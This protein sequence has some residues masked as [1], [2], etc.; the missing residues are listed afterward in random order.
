M[1]GR[2]VA[3]DPRDVAAHARD[4]ADARRRE[5]A[6]VLCGGGPGAYDIVRALGL[7]GIGSAVCSSEPGDVAFRSRYARQMLLLPE[8]GEA[9]FPRICDRLSAFSSARPDRP[10]LFHVGDSE[11]MFLSRFRNVLEASYRFLLPPPGVLEALM[12][13]VRFLDLA[14]K[15][16]LPVPA[17]QAF[18]EAAEV[19]AATIAMPCI[20]KPAYN[21]DWFWE[22]EALRTQFGDYK[23]ALRRFESRGALLEFCAALP[24][25]PAGF[26]V[27]SYVDGGDERIVSFH[28]YFDE[29]S[30]CLGSFLTREI[31]TNPPHSGDLA[32]CETIHDEDLA[33]LSVACL[34]RLGFRGIVKVDYK[35]DERARAYKMLEIEPHYQSWHLLGAY[36]GVNLP[37]IAYGH[38]RDARADRAGA[39]RES[40]RLLYF[41]QDFKAYWCG[42]RKTGEW[43][44]RRYLG[45]LVGKKHYRI[46]DPRDPLPFFYSSFRFIRRK[47][48]QFLRAAASRLRPRQDAARRGGGRRIESRL[49]PKPGR[50]ARGL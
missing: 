43:T 5:T 23:R 15:A 41:S 27:Q 8:F 1:T 20:V 10:V 12:S 44:W 13:K 2:G 37:L 45:S 17:A 24:R 42:Y 26:I 33:R 39:C 36:A 48:G 25:R 49:A 16:G 34:S 11:L 28:G 19:A 38:Q 46:Y 4:E 32:Y 31:R 40:V 18:T 47:V 3:S 30:R 7:A 29:A 6:A 50:G 35:W 14:R 21:Q 22:T 9:N